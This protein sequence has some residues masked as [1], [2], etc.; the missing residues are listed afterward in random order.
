MDSELGPDQTY[1][2]VVYLG[3]IDFSGYI[4]GNLVPH[5]TLFLVLSAARGGQMQGARAQE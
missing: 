5:F 4:E 3:P 1:D 2:Y